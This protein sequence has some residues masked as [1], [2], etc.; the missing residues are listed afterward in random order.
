[1]G[2]TR[3]R[4]LRRNVGWCD[5]G[6]QD[7]VR[8]RLEAPAVGSG[9]CRFR[10]G[11][12]IAELGGEFGNGDCR[13]VREHRLAPARA[14]GEMLRSAALRLVPS[15][16]SETL[17]F[18][19]AFGKDGGRFDGR[20]RVVAV[21]R[22]SGK[23]V[24]FGAPGAPPATV[25]QAL[26]AS[27]SSPP[28]YFAPAGRR[29][30]TRVRRWGRSGARPMPTSLR[31]P[32][33]DAEVLIVAPMASLHGPFNAPGSRQRHAPRCW[34]RRLRSRCGRGARVRIISPDQSSAVSIGPDLMSGA[35]PRRD[36]S[37]WLHAGPRLDTRV[38][39]PRR[40]Q[41]C[42]SRF[43]ARRVHVRDGSVTTCVACVTP[44]AGHPAG[45]RRRRRA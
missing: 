32:R 45:S 26:T 2:S 22:A 29:S 12:A 11:I 16:A 3:L 17:D 42:A 39:A 20:L 21:D 9:W 1:M 40:F 15:S 36:A 4:L 24:V 27:C 37:G 6:R 30:R 38:L 18:D 43:R 28:R 44:A 33:S 19:Q 5:R 7:R 25:A 13:T 14:P 35:Q 41:P 34:S 23:R 8:S 31:R 10:R